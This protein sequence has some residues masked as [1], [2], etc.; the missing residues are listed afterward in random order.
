MLQK[1]D[2]LKFLKKPQKTSLTAKKLTI[3]ISCFF[4][5]LL[6]LIVMQKTNNYLLEKS[7]R[8]VQQQLSKLQQ[9]LSINTKSPVASFDDRLMEYKKTN[10][11]GYSHL[12]DF[13]K[14]I[15]EINLC[16]IWL[17]KFDI[18]EGGNHVGL[19]GEFFQEGL[20]FKYQQALQQWPLLLDDVLT[21]RL[22]GPAQKEQS[23]KFSMQWNKRENT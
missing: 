12:A 6:I 2:F 9:Q 19:Q 22:T 23:Y 8:E 1:I 20:I 15:A 13:L 16:G 18:R 5:F 10:K 11:L 4:L 14:Q 3:Y 21:L 7:V 17:T